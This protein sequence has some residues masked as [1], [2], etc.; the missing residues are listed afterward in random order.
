MKELLKL[1]YFFFSIFP[2]LIFL[3]VSILHYWFSLNLFANIFTK[4]CEIGRKNGNKFNGR[5]RNKRMDK[6]ME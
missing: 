2:M 1:F 3:T 4:F 6:R 5:K